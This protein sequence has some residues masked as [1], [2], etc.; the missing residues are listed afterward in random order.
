MPARRS[1]CGLARRHAERASRD[2]DRP[3]CGG[4]RLSGGRLRRATRAAKTPGDVAV[5]D[6]ADRRR[7]A[8]PSSASSAARRDRRTR[9]ADR[10]RSGTAT[11]G[12]SVSAPIAVASDGVQAGDHDEAVDVGAAACR[13]RA[14]RGAG[15]RPT[16]ST[17]TTSVPVTRAT[18][19]ASAATGASPPPAHSTRDPAARLGQRADGGGHRGGVHRRVRVVLARP[20]RPASPRVARSTTRRPVGVLA[21]G[22][23][24]QGEHLLGACGRCPRRPRARPRPRDGPGRRAGAV[25]RRRARGPGRA[26]ARRRC[27][28]PSGGSAGAA[29]RAAGRSRRLPSAVARRCVGEAHGAPSA[30]S[31]AASGAGGL[32]RLAPNSASG[33]LTAGRAGLGDPGQ[34]D[35]AVAAAALGVVEHAVGGGEQR[36]PVVA[37]GGRGDAHAD[38]HRDVRG[39]ARPSRRPRPCGGCAPAPARPARRWCRAA[40]STNSSPA[41]RHT[42]SVSRTPATSSSPTRRSTASPPGCPIGVV[43][44]LEVVDVDDGQRRRGAG[45]EQPVQP[46]LGVAPVGQVGQRVLVGLAAQLAGG[47]LG[48]QQALAPAEQLHPA[49]AP[50]VDPVQLVGEV[51]LQVGQRPAGVVQVGVQRAQLA[52]RGA[53]QP[54]QA[55]LG[56]QG[57]RG[58][59]VLVGGRARRPG[60]A[61][62]GPA[63]AARRRAAPGRRWPT[64]IADGGPQRAG[65]PRRARRGPTSAQPCTTWAATTPGASGG[66]SSQRLL[67]QRAGPR[68]SAGPPTRGRRRPADPRRARRTA[69]PGGWRSSA[70][71]DAGSPTSAPSDAGLGRGER[72]LVRAALV[73]QRQRHQ[74]EVGEHAGQRAEG[75]AP[76]GRLGGRA[77]SSRLAASTASSIA[78]SIRRESSSMRACRARPAARCR[79]SS[80]AS[81]AALAERTS[82]IA[83]AAREADSERRVRVGVGRPSISSATPACRS[84]AGSVASGAGARPGRRRRVKPATRS[85]RTS[86]SARRVSAQARPREP[87]AARR[88]WPAAGRRRRRETDRARHRRAVP[89]RRRAASSSARRSPDGA[90]LR[91]ARAHCARRSRRCRARVRKRAVPRPS[92]PSCPTRGAAAHASS[93]VVR[94]CVLAFHGRAGARRPDPVAAARAWRRTGAGR[95][96]RT[97]PASRRGRPLAVAT[98]GALAT[99]ML[100]VTGSGSSQVA[101]SRRR[102]RR[103]AAAP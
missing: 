8:R 49:G 99:P 21:A 48:L 17:R 88:P 37:A 56:G 2:R 53:A 44:L 5:V 6:G 7:P 33:G 31:R 97:A 16:S 84:S 52:Q 96:C 62:R 70:T 42:S 14:A 55:V 87:G 4:S 82:A 34:P 72:G 91:V 28:A 18:K 86:S 51:G 40:G 12:T 47:P 65:R 71:S 13:R 25:H 79:S 76:A 15:C 43:D 27:R 67:G 20:G 93:V 101:P 63:P 29:P 85:R 9:R 73:V 36:A 90:G 60:G 95:R 35:H 1:S 94:R 19:A 64:V 61:A 57:Q 69:R 89:R 102:P 75:V 66:S 32:R 10:S 24:D 54:G 74:L 103:C 98:A 46:G 83:S 23:A 41:Q 59:E 50:L 81:K 45:G 3:D 30:S 58:D 39:P 38:R 78:A 22:L 77:G 11:T 92:R 100:T 26:A 68:R 80:V